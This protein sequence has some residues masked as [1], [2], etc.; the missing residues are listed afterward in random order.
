MCQVQSACKCNFFPNYATIGKLVQDINHFYF[1]IYLC[2]A[3]QA[4]YISASAVSK[5]L[6]LASFFTAGK[7]LA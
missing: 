2:H 1:F 4:V 5:V 6:F 7:L 3:G